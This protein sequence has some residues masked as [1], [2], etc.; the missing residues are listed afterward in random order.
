[1]L[2]FG[3][4][5]AFLFGGGF[6]FGFQR[7]LGRGDFRDALL[8]VRHKVRHFVATLVA[9]E[10]RIFLRVRCF[11]GGQPA[12]DLGLQ[13]GFPF[14]YVR[15]AHCFVFRRVRLDFRA[16]ERDVAKLGHPAAAHSSRT[17]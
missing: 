11:R 13:F 9:A 5:A 10:L 12:I 2:F 1:L 14:L 6:R 3:L 4:D 8:L 15:L 16:V 7:R 17:C